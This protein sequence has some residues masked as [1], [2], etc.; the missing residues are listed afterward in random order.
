MHGSSCM[1]PPLDLR[2]LH[3][4]PRT[5]VCAAAYDH[6]GMTTVLSVTIRYTTD[7]PLTTVWSDADRSATVAAFPDHGKSV[8][9]SANQTKPQANR[10][11]FAGPCWSVPS[12]A[13]LRF[14]H[15]GRSP[16]FYCSIHLPF[17][18]AGICLPCDGRAVHLCDSFEAKKSPEDRPTTTRGGRNLFAFAKDFIADR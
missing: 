14:A 3:E 11:P 5:T 8:E 9:K 13:G 7:G 16:G 10:P 6:M 1:A 18:A 4:Q 2:S 17:G 12:L 15:R